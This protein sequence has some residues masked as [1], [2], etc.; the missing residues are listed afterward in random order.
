MSVRSNAAVASGLFNLTYPNAVSYIKHV[1]FSLFI[2]KDRKS[3]VLKRQVNFQFFLK[4]I[5]TNLLVYIP[6]FEFH[7]SIFGL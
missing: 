2:N 7:S 4:E 6:I 3:L 1:T 5:V